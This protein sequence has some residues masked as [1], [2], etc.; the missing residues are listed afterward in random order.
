MFGPLAITV[1]IAL[2][3]SLFLS[4]FVI[5]VLCLLFL[6]PH[7]E[8]ESFIM[9]HAKNRYLPLL[10]YA[11]NK[12]RVILSVAGAFLVASLFLVTR[13][14]TEFIPTW[15]KARLIWMCPCFPVFPLR[16]RWK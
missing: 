10:E 8:K 5:P 7:P 14:G 6:K 11:M 4:V 15:M 2:L 13:L 1:A 9:K 3:S 12:K 16:K